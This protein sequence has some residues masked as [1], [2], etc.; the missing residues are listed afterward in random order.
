[1]TMATV[2]MS[3]SMSSPSMRSETVFRFELVSRINTISQECGWVGELRR[4][5]PVA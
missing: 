4:G 2:S 1:V 5:G 3:V